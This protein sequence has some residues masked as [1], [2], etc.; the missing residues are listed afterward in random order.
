MLRLDP[1]APAFLTALV[2]LLLLV[3]VSACETTQEL[4]PEL[5]G[6][7]CVFL[8]PAV[9]SKLGPGS[10]G[11]PGLRYKAPNVDWSQYTK[12]MISPVTFWGSE[13]G[14]LDA[15]QRQALA[16]YL[17][18][19]FVKQIGA[20][21]PVVD[22]PGPGVMK[23]QAALTDASAATPVLRTVSMTV[24]QARALAT[25]KYAVTGTY[26]FVGTTQGELELTD[27]QTGQLLGAAVDR[28]A[29]GG[30]V[31]T[32]A[33]WQW[34]DAQNVMDTWASMTANRL[35]DLR[36]GGGNR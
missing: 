29:G 36:T 33:Q 14:R 5:Q 10:A 34:G 7:R 30:S 26:P 20:K 18:D 4:K 25:L 1:N 13:N 27:S 17:Y 2:P 9:C 24:P 28:R 16:D 35:E 12:I 15:G 21:M 8:A 11:Q 3:G 22:Q 23:L 6:G 31:E 19:A 32:A